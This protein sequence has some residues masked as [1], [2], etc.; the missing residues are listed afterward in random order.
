MMRKYDLIPADSHFRRTFLDNIAL[1]RE[2][3]LAFQPEL[4]G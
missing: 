1:H 4:K 3:L 2:I